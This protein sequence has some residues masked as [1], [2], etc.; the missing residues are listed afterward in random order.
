MNV[1]F[2]DIELSMIMLCVVPNALSLAYWAKMGVGHFPT[3]EKEI[4]KELLLLKPEFRRSQQIQ[5]ILKRQNT[6]RK[7]STAKSI[8]KRGEAKS[9]SNRGDSFGKIPRKSAQ[10]GG[11][12]GQSVSTPKGRTG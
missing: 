4:C 5:D 9:A 2:D 7:S 10:N 6:Q 3:S 12:D 1:P 8:E 11:K